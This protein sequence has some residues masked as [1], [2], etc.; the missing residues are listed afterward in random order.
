MPT[1]RDLMTVNVVTLAPSASVRDAIGTLLRRGVSGAPVVEGDRVAG[2]VSVTD[3]L[4][5]AASLPGV[6]A[7]RPAES[8]PQE[9]E[10]AA[11]WKDGDEPPSTYFADL[12][13]DAGAELEARFAGVGAPEWDALE[14]HTVSE[15]MTRD[16]C[17][18]PP[19]ATIAAAADY[20]RRAGIHRLLVMD[21]SRLLGLVS[22]S[23]VARA[24][25]EGRAVDRHSVFDADDSFDERG[26]R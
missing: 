3:L 19:D 9:E 17:A 4:G 21:E 10:P 20:M 14:E 12:W 11:T 24:V 25:A 5:F 23:D 22:A 7:E 16:V 26:W 18:L 1:V 8:E 6:P 15:V 2:V 13:D